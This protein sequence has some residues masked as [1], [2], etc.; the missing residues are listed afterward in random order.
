MLGFLQSFAFVERENFGCPPRGDVW[1]FG[2]G[3]FDDPRSGQKAWRAASEG[4]RADWP[5]I[6]IRIFRP[7]RQTGPALESVSPIP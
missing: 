4:S 3:A 1:D 6:K 2:C 7:G 5:Y